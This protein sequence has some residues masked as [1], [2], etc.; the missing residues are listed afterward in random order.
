MGLCDYKTQNDYFRIG[1]VC[2]LPVSESICSDQPL[3]TTATLTSSLLS[4]LVKVNRDIHWTEV[5]LNWPNLS[6]RYNGRNLWLLFT[7]FQLVS[8]DVLDISV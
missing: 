8:S 1:K 7:G 4:A 5:S 2:K 6:L 3:I